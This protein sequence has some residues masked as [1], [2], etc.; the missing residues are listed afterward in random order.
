M[1]AEAEGL[2]TAYIGYL[3]FRALYQMM[4]TVARYIY[5]VFRVLY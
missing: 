3:V 5:L 4:I 1:M 2:W